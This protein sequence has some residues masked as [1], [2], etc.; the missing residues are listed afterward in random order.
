MKRFIYLIL[1]S[2]LLLVACGGDD[3][4]TA[5]VEQAPA[6]V[7]TEAAVAEA[8]STAVADEPEAAVQQNDGGLGGDAG[9]QNNPTPIE[10]GSYAGSLRGSDVVDVYAIPSKPY[11]LVSVTVTNAADSAAPLEV[12]LRHVTNEEWDANIAPGESQTLVVAANTSQTNQLQLFSA[13]SETVNYQMIIAVETEND[14]SSG[15]DIPG[16]PAQ[17]VPVVM[18]ETVSGTSIRIEGQ[19]GHDA[20]CYLVEGVAEGLLTAEISAPAEQ[21]YESFASVELYNSAGEYIWGAQA[22]YGT[23]SLLEQTVSA[24]DYVLCVETYEYYPVGFYTLTVNPGGVGIGTSEGS[25]A[26]ETN[27]EESNGTAETT[28]AGNG[29]AD[30]LIGTWRVSNFDDYF[31]AVV[32]SAMADSSQTMEITSTSSGDLLLTFDGTN[33]TMSDNNFQVVVTV[34][35]QTVPVDIEAAGSATYTVEDGILTGEIDNVNVDDI[36]T[37]L[38]YGVS[39]IVGQPI[40][41]SCEGD[42]LSWLDQSGYTVMLSRVN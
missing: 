16:E 27:G 25:E 22:D 15:A 4:P 30:C 19:G 37:G 32:Q 40:S 24:G 12:T 36:N 39:N 8:P 29:D 9:D 7:P 20:D 6:E 42:R 3:E 23:S 11:E 1:M 13:A 10:P 33:M 38:G 5:D 17:A 31:A 35:G 2:I 26:A 21:P 41:F 28:T 34:A 14:A 18:G